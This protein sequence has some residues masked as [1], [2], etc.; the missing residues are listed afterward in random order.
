MAMF[1][2]TTLAIAA[3]LLAV[4]AQAQT[5]YW[6]GTTGTSAP[7]WSTLDAWSTI[8]GGF[9]A[10]T[11]IPGASNG[12]VFNITPLVDP[13]TVYLDGNQAALGLTFSSAG[14][15]TLLGVTPS[16][17]LEPGLVRESSCPRWGWKGFSDEEAT[18]CRADRGLASAG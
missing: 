6:S 3:G 15:T 10:P 8:A 18:Q 9:T 1:L 7:R 2:R 4:A 5:L 17:N 16:P 12:V 11:A 14:A 13:Q